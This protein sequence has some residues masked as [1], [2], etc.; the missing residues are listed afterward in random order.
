VRDTEHVLPRLRR[1]PW[2]PAASHPIPP[3][4]PGRPG[5][6]GK[7]LVRSCRPS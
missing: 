3:A 5:H 1:T 2:H 7:S 6:P 4:A